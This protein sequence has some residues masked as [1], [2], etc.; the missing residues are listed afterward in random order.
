MTT[1]ATYTDLR[2]R[3]EQ[4]F[5]T[6]A[7]ELHVWSSFHAVGNKDQHALQQARERLELARRRYWESRNKLADFLLD[8]DRGV[9][10][11]RATS[12]HHGA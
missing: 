9:S 8:N 1:D 4:A 2:S 7:E 6:L 11:F 5:R 10:A 3:Y 12:G